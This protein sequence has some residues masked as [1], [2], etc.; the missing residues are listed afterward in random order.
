MKEGGIAS[1]GISYVTI[2]D[3][4]TILDEFETALAAHRSA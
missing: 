4:V 3:I 1:F 2:E